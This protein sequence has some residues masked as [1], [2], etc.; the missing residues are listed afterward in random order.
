MISRSPS[1]LWGQ[2]Q[3]PVMMLPHWGLKPPEKGSSGQVSAAF[4]AGVVRKIDHCI[5]PK[6]N[7][8][9]QKY[10]V[11]KAADIEPNGPNVPPVLPVP[12]LVPL[13]GAPAAS[14]LVR[15][16]D[17]SWSCCQKC[18][19]LYIYIYKLIWIL[20]TTLTLITLMAGGSFHQDK[21]LIRCYCPAAVRLLLHVL[22]ACRPEQRYGTARG[23]LASC[24]TK[25]DF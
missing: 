25:A 6:S 4:L 12:G 20:G 14:G 7:K 24:N 8:Q 9:A 3:Q 5:E 2:Q 15:V 19:I 13:P 10:V 18:H 1:S 22:L 23:S 21:H 11:Q 16:T 17:S